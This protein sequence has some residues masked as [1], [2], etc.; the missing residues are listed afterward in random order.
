MQ[1]VSRHCDLFVVFC[2]LS[3]SHLI[4]T[5]VGVSKLLESYLVDDVGSALVL[6]PYFSTIMLGSCGVLAAVEENDVCWS[7]GILEN[8]VLSAM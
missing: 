6:N 5:C 1:E 3:N 4:C 2:V 8:I 7:I